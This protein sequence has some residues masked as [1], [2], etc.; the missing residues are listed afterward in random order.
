M[1]LQFAAL[2][3]L[4]TATSA[5]AVVQEKTLGESFDDASASNQ[6][7]SRLLSASAAAFGE[8]DVEVT[9]RLV[10]LTGRVANPELKQE[11]ERIAWS[12][13]TIDEVANELEIMPDT[14]LLKNVN[15]EWITARVRSRLVGDA[16]IKS[17]NYNIETYNGTVYLL[18]LAR[19]QDELKRAAEHASVIAGVKRVVSY[20]K[21]RNRAAPTYTAQPS[22]P[23]ESEELYG[24]V[25]ATPNY[26]PKPEFATPNASPEWRKDAQYDKDGFLIEPQD[27]NP[28]QGAT[29]GY[30]DPY[31]DPFD[32]ET[33]N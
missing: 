11:A 14:S 17:V 33:Y 7:K 32:D 25:E 15:D 20:V 5:C 21:M 2:A 29:E 27:V 22:A 12:V 3:V 8:V 9:S 10:L 13:R 6:I 31:A 4:L 1:K 18:G 23:V 26:A 24:S 28:D 19:D 30:K 16:A